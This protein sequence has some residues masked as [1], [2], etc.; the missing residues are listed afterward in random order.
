MDPG[1]DGEDDRWRFRDGFTPGLMTAELGPFADE[2]LAVLNS[3][4]IQNEP[5]V[6]P[7][8]IAISRD[9]GPPAVL[10]A[11]RDQDY[12]PQHKVDWADT[13]TYYPGLYDTRPSDG[14]SFYDDHDPGVAYG[15]VEA[16]SAH[17]GS[18]V[19]PH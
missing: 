3:R 7:K 19:T 14:Q 18:Q 6:N 13:T 17:M 1:D 15:G 4:G 16:A 10:T 8:D 2:D 12:D 11:E 9:S 5:T